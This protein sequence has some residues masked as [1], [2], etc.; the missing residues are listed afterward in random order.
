MF[1]SPSINPRRINGSDGE[2]YKCGGRLAMVGR[3]RHRGRLVGW[4]DVVVGS[5]L[6]VTIVEVLAGARGRRGLA[7]IRTR[8]FADCQQH[9]NRGRESVCLS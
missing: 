8:D 3:G 1:D 7:P 9:Q 6:V 2:T 4:V 5:L